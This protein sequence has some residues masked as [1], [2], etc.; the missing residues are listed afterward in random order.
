MKLICETF[1]L[2]ILLGSKHLN[3]TPRNL[4]RSS[5]INWSNTIL[6]SVKDAHKILGDKVIIS[7]VLASDLKLTS[8]K[9]DV[10]TL[11][12]SDSP[13]AFGLISNMR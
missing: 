5:K 7:G 1:L 4:K 10:Y 9:G 6:M 13:D 11:S 12:I 2:S 8:G 3:E